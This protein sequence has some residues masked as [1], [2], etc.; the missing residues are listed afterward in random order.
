METLRQRSESK[1]KI[2]NN[3][4]LQSKQETPEVIR[5]AEE[6]AIEKLNSIN[7]QNNIQSTEITKPPL[8]WKPS[9]RGK[10]V[11][12]NSLRPPSPVAG[13]GRGRGNTVRG[14]G[15]PRGRGG[16]KPPQY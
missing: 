10:P 16:P 13:S 11:P 7:Q 6:R 5:K 8:A 9:K 12:D 2:G 1:T 14:R 15:I 4:I 3:E